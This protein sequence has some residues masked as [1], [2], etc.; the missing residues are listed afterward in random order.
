ME[1]STITDFILTPFDIKLNLVLVIW[2]FAS[3]Y[4]SLKNKVNNYDIKIKELK[5]HIISILIDEAISQ[6]RR[7]RLQKK[8]KL[9]KN[10]N[11]KLKNIISRT[12]R[13]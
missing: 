1:F 10:E 11:K 3:I 4:L 6:K 5:I 8:I 13:K 9:L 2:I 12:T 7:I